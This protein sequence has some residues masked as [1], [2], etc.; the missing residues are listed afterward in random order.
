VFS[1][2]YAWSG[3]TD[4]WNHCALNVCLYGPRAARWAMTER[5]RGAVEASPG[6]IRIG[7]SAVRWDGAALAFEID[8]RGAPLPRRVRGSVRVI[9]ETVAARTHALDADGRHLWRPVMP[10]ARV[11]ARFSEPDLSWS[12]PGYSDVNAGSEPLEQ[13]FERWDWSRVHGARDAAILYDSRWRGGGGRSLAL[14]FGADG[15]AE[16]FEPPPRRPLPRAGWG[17]ARAI[18][19]EGEARVARTLEDTPFYAR[20]I[21]ETRL[22]GTRCE[23]MHETVD[24]SRFS[25]NWVRAL[26]P[27]RMPRAL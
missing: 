6:R 27:F 17:V 2:Y 3:R 13:G 16:P 5:G 26:L 22:S 1:P 7:P 18:Q 23:A 25:R 21:V 9:P 14:R 10:R 12:G 8:E 20:S 19:S 24:L 11:E 15:T 4:P